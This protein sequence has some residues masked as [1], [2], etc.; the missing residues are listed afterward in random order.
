[1]SGVAELL[2]HLD[3]GGDDRRAVGQDTFA[4]DEPAQDLAR[5]RQAARALVGGLGALDRIG[6]A[7]DI[8]VLHVL[9]DAAQL[10]HDGHTDPAQMLGIADPGQLQDVRRANRA[11][12]Q[13]DL[14]PRIGLLDGAAARE[15]D[16]GCALAVEQDAMH[17]GVGD[18]LQVRPFQCRVQIGARGA[19]AAAAAARLLA[20]ADAVRVAVR[21]V[22]DVLAVF[23][24][25]LLAGLEHGGADRR[26]VS[27]RGEERP[28][29]AA[30]IAAFA[31]PALGLAEIGQAIVPRPA[32]IT[33]LRPVVVI[34][35]LAAD[36]DQPV[37]RGGAADHPAARVDDRTTVGAGVRLGADIS[38]SGCRDRAS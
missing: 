32:A 23:E 16:A 17:E 19:G 6:D 31:L 3:R 1:M 12:R 34:L 21:Q 33:E 14:T 27:L 15:L 11:R 37:D 24:P 26:P 25:D 9:A 13:D 38:T 2:Q 8:V 7:R 4:G 18:E 29:L 10:V 28:V 36:V 30:H 22:V 20:P 35:G 5:E